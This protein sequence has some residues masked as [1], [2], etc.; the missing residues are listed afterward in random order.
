MELSR[1]DNLRPVEQP[2]YS[3]IREPGGVE[4]TAIYKKTHMIRWFGKFWDFEVCNASL[5][6]VGL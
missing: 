5:Q 2:A 4:F 6:S 3:H 1:A